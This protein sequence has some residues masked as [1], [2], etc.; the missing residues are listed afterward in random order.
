M[1]GSYL[2][3]DRSPDGEL[4]RSVLPRSL[5][6]GQSADVQLRIPTAK[7]G[8]ADAIA[9]DLVREGVNWFAD[10]GSPAVVV[11]LTRQD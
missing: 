1:V 8:S 7:L 2:P 4:A 11:P 9:I 10:R 3:N 5:A 6:T